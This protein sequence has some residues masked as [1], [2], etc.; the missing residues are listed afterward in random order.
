MTWTTSPGSAYRLEATTDFRTWSPVGASVTASGTTAEVLV[1][2]GDV[3]AGAGF[4]RVTA[5]G[6]SSAR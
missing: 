2:L 6:P 5:G 3:A 4:Y 1:P